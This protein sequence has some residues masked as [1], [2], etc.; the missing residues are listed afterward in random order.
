VGRPPPPK[1]NAGNPYEP[2]PA[3][4]TVLSNSLQRT[5]EHDWNIENVTFLGSLAMY[6]VPANYY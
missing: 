2:T 6:T 5:C 4:T 1:K 3:V